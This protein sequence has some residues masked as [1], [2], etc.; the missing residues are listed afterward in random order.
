[1]KLRKLKKSN[2]GEYDGILYLKIKR[3]LNDVDIDSQQII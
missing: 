3:S 1:M 2:S